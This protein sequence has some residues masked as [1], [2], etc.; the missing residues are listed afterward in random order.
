MGKELYDD[1]IHEAR[2][3]TDDFNP[4][5]NPFFNS[6]KLLSHH[7]LLWHF[8]WVLRSLIEEKSEIKSTR[9]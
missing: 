6:L 4:L 9:H 8:N 1:K 2:I 7:A 5:Y 3:I